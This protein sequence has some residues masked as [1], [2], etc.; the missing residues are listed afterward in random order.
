MARA[1]FTPCP[2]DGT[3]GAIANGGEHLTEKNRLP[4][5]RFYLGHKA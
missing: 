5:Q 4:Q 3:V 1:D 2:Q